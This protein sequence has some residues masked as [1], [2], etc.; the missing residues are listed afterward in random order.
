MIRR[1]S[2]ENWKMQR[3]AV[4]LCS[5]SLNPGVTQV[6]EASQ[7]GDVDKLRNILKQMQAHKINTALHT[8]AYNHT[9]ATENGATFNFL[10]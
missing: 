7:T 1:L 3:N 9:A 2:Q 10:L 8:M 6:F 5:Y 4:R